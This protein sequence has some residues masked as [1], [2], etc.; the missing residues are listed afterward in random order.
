M[1]ILVLAV[2]LAMASALLW[3][4]L[5]KAGRL[6]AVATTL[7][8]LGVPERGGRVVAPL[9]VAAELS[10]AVGLFFRPWSV[11]TL[12]GVLTL[13]A[14]FA[15][16]GLIALLH[17][18]K[19]RCGCFGPHGGAHLGKNQLVAFPFWCAAVALVWWNGPMRSSDWPGAFGLAVVALT[20][21]TFRGVNS[22]R[23]AHEA[24]G[25]RRSAQEMLVWLKR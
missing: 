23:A 22:L 5:E 7:H 10:V 16:S 4:G 11:A 3:A 24:R 25:D 8:Q 20:M 12:T 14:A 6:F 13:A 15:I 18:Q 21:A 19:I 17:K 9:I 1:T 2:T